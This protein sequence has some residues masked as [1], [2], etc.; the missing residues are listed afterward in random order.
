MNELHIEPDRYDGNP[1]VPIITSESIRYKGSD[2][3]IECEIGDDSD[4]A[5]HFDA[6]NGV[7]DHTSLETARSLMVAIRELDNRVQE[8]CAAE[9]RRTKLHPRN[10]QSALAYVVVLPGRASLRYFGTGVNTEWDEQVRF[11]GDKWELL[12]IGV[13]ANP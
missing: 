11:D 12:P 1:V 10:Y 13:P 5:I 6:A 3:W 7:V 8:S 2:A 9:C 4:F